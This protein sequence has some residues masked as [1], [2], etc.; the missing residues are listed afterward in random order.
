MDGTCDVMNEERDGGWGDGAAGSGRGLLKRSGGKGDGEGSESD[1]VLKRS[2]D[3]EEGAREDG[4]EH[5]KSGCCRKRRKKGK[6]QGDLGNESK[7][8]DGRGVKGQEGKGVQ[9]VTG[10]EDVND[11]FFQAV[12]GEPEKAGTDAESGNKLLQAGGPEADEA[13]QLRVQPLTRCVLQREPLFDQMIANWYSGDQGIKPHVDLLRFDDGIAIL[14]L[15]SPCVMTLAPA[16]P[17]TTSATRTTIATPTATAAT[18]ASP[19]PSAPHE[20]PVEPP[21]SSYGD[22]RSPDA[23]A[24]PSTAARNN[25]GG[26]RL[27]NAWGDDFGNG[28]MRPRPV[29]SLQHFVLQAKGRALYRDAFRTARLAPPESRADLQKMIREEAE[30]HAGESDISKIRFYMSEGMQRLKELK[31]MLDN[32]G[33]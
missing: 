4:E 32:Q 26:A 10:V 31:S 25:Q 27:A 8:E 5:G 20:F 29:F 22:M 17:T 30:K 18:N 16:P 1:L 6:Q 12:G 2:G 19:P 21:P 13:E 15:L 7:R 24:A 11:E 3:R 28:G 9:E 14:S 23:A 33:R